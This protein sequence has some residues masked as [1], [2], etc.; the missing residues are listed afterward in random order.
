MEM[1]QHEEEMSKSAALF[2][3]YFRAS[4]HICKFIILV[5]LLVASQAVLN[6]SDIVLTW[7][8]A[9]N[10]DPNDPSNDNSTEVVFQGLDSNSTSSNMNGYNYQTHLN[11]SA[12]IKKYFTNDS[13]YIY[14]TLI[15]LT[16][17]LTFI[18]STW[19]MMTCMKSSINLHNRMFS[20]LMRS[21][22]RFF[23]NN[24][25][26]RILNR[27]SKDI[28]TMDEILPKTMLEA[29]QVIYSR[30]RVH[31]SQFTIYSLF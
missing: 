1:D 19:F 9:T 4:G 26:G 20:C 12:D 30:A 25:S 7:W 5:F 22:M 29:I 24:P 10:P 21:V 15:I 11:N 6:A 23:D 8:I 14:A 31:L 18:R 17:F 16:V 27:F 2:W 3:P 13:F 28:G